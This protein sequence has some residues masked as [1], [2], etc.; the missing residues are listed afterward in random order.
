MVKIH[1][2][3]PLLVIYNPFLKPIFHTLELPFFCSFSWFSCNMTIIS[4]NF[5][6]SLLSLFTELWEF[7]NF[8]L[9]WLYSLPFENLCLSFE[10]FLKELILS[11]I[12]LTWLN[13]FLNFVVT[14]PCMSLIYFFLLILIS[15]FICLNL[16]PGPF[17]IP[18]W[19]LPTFMVTDLCEKEPGEGQVEITWKKY[20]AFNGTWGLKHILRNTIIIL[21]KE[22]MS[23]NFPACPLQRLSAGPLGLVAPHLA[24][25]YTPRVNSSAKKPSC[26]WWKCSSA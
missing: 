16:G 1:D 7:T 2:S 25:P 10:A 9:L 3:Y 13:N 22:C 26:R 20:L 5:F 8:F 24:S 19:L 17:A 14:F 12:S 4:E 11:A 21:P 6:I 18:L 15:F 23:S